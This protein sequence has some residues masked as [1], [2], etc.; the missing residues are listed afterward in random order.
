MSTTHIQHDI[1]EFYN[2]YDPQKNHINEYAAEDGYMYET[3][4][5]EITYIH[6]ILK[7]YPQRIWTVVDNNDGWYGI[8]AGCHHVNRMGYMITHEEWQSEDEEY[9]IYDNT[10]L[11]EQWDNLPVQAIEELIGE[12][13]W[14]LSEDE[15]QDARDGHFWIWEEYG[16]IERDEIIAKYKQP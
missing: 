14:D 5:P 11:R 1:E 8:V 7:Q 3:Y 12:T 4:G 15:I 16:E 13:I 6:E 9:T 10:G 2:L